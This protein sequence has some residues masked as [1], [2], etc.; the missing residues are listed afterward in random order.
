MPRSKRAHRAIVTNLK[1][2]PAP[3]K[4][5]NTRTAAAASTAA[6]AAITAA[7]LASKPERVRPAF[8]SHLTPAEEAAIAASVATTEARLAALV[9]KPNA[10]PT[11][12]DL[13]F[14]DPVMRRLEE[15]KHIPGM[16]A[17]IMNEENA[18]NPR[19][20]SLVDLVSSIPLPPALPTLRNS[21]LSVVKTNIKPEVK[22]TKKRT[23]GHQILVGNLPPG[24]TAQ[25]LTA[26]FGNIGT[27]TD[28]H[29]PI[30]PAS[31]RTRG[32]A[33]IT[34]AEADAILAALAMESVTFYNR[35]K[36]RHDVATIQVAEG[37]RKGAKEMKARK[38]E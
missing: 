12:R 37:K 11:F 4:R 21:S 2:I 1:S 17:N 13:Y 6:P 8:V 26:V 22:G 3:K 5:N 23:G 25:E 7:V 29:I 28:I 34:F 30:D 15:G 18:R 14:A 24:I 16:W 35:I 10:A 27:V 33:F 36:K 19:P 31:K 32:I 9:K 20:R 38:P